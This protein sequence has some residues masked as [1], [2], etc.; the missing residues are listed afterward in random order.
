MLGNFSCFFAVF[1]YFFFKILKV[2]KKLFQE[3]HLSS[4][5]DP[6]KARHNFGPNPGP[7]CLQRLSVDNTGRLKS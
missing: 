3:F 5:S 1:R 6:E 4:N 7:N 2:F